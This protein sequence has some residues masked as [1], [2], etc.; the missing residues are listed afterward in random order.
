MALTEVQGL[1]IITAVLTFLLCICEPGFSSKRFYFS[2]CFPSA[3]AASSVIFKIIFPC[4]N[5]AIFLIQENSF[6]KNMIL[7]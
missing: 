5:N 3:F 1:Y 2:L 6:L 4:M 7:C